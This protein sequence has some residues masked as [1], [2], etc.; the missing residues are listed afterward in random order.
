MHN[1]VLLIVFSVLLLYL[2]GGCVCVL[3]LCLAACLCA[4][5]QRNEYWHNQYT[6]R[7][8]VK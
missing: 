7:I 4:G 2:L 1:I 6:N 3:C 8:L 5:F